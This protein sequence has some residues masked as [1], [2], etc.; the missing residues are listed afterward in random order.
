MLADMFG[1]ICLEVPV[2]RLVK[3]NDD[4][5]YFTDTQLSCSMSLLTSISKQLLFLDGL[6]DLT[7]I[8]YLY[9]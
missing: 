1:V 8:I 4:R 2:S 9:K 5:Q 6:E 3:V 7:E